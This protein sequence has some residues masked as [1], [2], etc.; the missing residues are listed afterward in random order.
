MGHYQRSLVSVDVPEFAREL[1]GAERPAV[2]QALGLGLV[3]GRLFGEDLGGEVLGVVLGA[4]ADA[5][6]AR[7]VPPA[8]WRRRAWGWGPFPALRNGR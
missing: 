2:E 3:V 5:L 4:V 6:A 8:L 1:H 7:V